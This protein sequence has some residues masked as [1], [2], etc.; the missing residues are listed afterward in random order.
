LWPKV[1]AA[2]GLIDVAGFAVTS[3]KVGKAGQTPIEARSVQAVPNPADTYPVG[4]AILLSKKYPDA[5]KATG[6][7]YG[8]FQTLIR[9]EAKEKAA[10][11]SVGQT[12]THEAAYNI[13]GEANWKPFATAIESAHVTFQKFIGEPSNAGSLDKAMA[14][15][16]YVPE[17]RLFETNFYDPEYVDYAGAAANGAF[18]GTT[19]LP[20]EEASKYPATKQYLEGIEKHGGV[21]SFMGLQSTSAWLLFA[22]LAKECDTANNLTRTCILE[23]AAKVTEWS[24]GGLHAPSN[25]GENK[26]SSCTLVLQVK[27]GKFTRWAPTDEDYVC[28]PT[29]IAHVGGE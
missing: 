16:G 5:G 23:G 9:Q 2:C 7:I 20:M 26:G 1:G 6:L 24:G 21:P 28:D 11:T 18:I 22:K 10:F 13:M 8:D 14:E 19:F 27:D 15:V 12:V 4:P 3:E 17:V 25:P 29:Y